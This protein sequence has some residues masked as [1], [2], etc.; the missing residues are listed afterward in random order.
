M[1]VFH[2]F[3]SLSVG[4]KGPAEDYRKSFE[5]LE[6]ALYWARGS[7]SYKWE[8]MKTMDDGSLRLVRWGGVNHEA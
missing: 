2:V 7:R 8:I 5:E 6:V 1:K 4:Y 3:T